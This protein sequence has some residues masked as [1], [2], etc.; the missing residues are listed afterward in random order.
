MDESTI[1]Y[2][3]RNAARLSERYESITGSVAQYFQ[4]A[5]PVGARVLDIGA[6][7]G[8]DTVQLLSLGYDAYGVEP[9]QEM[10]AQALDLHPEL[11]DR[12]G[13]SALPN[14]GQPFEGAFD[15]VLCSAVLMHLPREQ[16]LDAAFAIRDVLRE[17]GRLLIS[18]PSARPDLTPDHRDANG[19]LFTPLPAD[20]LELLF[21]R[22][23]FHLVSKWVSDDGLKREGYTWRTLLFHLHLG[24][25]LRAADQIE[26]ILTRDRK[27]ATYKLAL[28]RALS[29]IAV[30][31]FEQAQWLDNSIVAVPV[32]PVCERWLAYYWPLFEAPTFIPQIRGESEVCA[33]PVAFRHA[34]VDL[35]RCYASSG[36]L[37]RFMLDYRGQT[38]PPQA[39]GLT[40]DAL[41]RI[42]NTIIKGPVTY[43]GGALETGRVF[44]YNSK[45][46]AIEMDAAIWRELSLLGHWIQDAIIL[47]W[48]ELTAEISRKGVATSQVIELLLTTPLPERDVFDARQAYAQLRLKECVWTGRSLS[49][50]FDVDHIIPFSLWHNNDLW[51]LVPALPTVN[52]QKREKL[53]TRELLSRRKDCIISY[54]ETLHN[55]YTRRFDFEAARLVGKQTSASW[56]ESTFHTVVEAVEI[57]A[58]QRGCERWQP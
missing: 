38:I 48:A 25:G 29:E 19:R 46:D 5:F 51:N 50:D 15:G 14:L 9:S 35:V 6:G 12:L 17:G 32:E 55:S 24:D 42:R 30:K 18:I 10:R 57:T 11:C 26:G 49:R 16:I 31:E 45:L 37:G 36:G 28:F 23:G 2:Y 22:L 27:T 52:N 13:A 34:L 54:W 20:Y 56:Q 8:R 21:E 3:S 44:R 4:V 1:R 41:K 58:I 53:P 47:R 40:T 39:A 43:A 7:S 33:M